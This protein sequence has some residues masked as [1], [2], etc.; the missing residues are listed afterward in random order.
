MAEGLLLLFCWL[1][2]AE[3]GVWVPWVPGAIALP[4]AALTTQA[5]LKVTERRESVK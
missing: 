1:W 2:L 5:T 3:L 4:I